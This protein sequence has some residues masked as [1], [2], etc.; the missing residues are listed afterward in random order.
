[1]N[2]PEAGP[3]NVSL[4]SAS[5]LIVDD[6][7]INIQV[8]NQILGGLYQLTFARSGQEALDL[9]LSDP[10][11]LILMDV[12][13]PE[14][15]GLATCKIIKNTPDIS[16]IPVVFIT[17]LQAAEEENACWEAGGI[18]YMIKPVNPL[19]LK[20]RIKAHLTLK[21][22]ADLLKKLAYVDGLTSVYNRRYL[23]DYVLQQ[24]AQAKRAK[25]SLSLLM[26][27]IDYFKQFNDQYGH[28]YADDQLKSVALNLRGTLRRPLDIVARYGGEEFVCVLP[29]T[30]ELG[31]NHVARLMIKSIADLKINH[32]LS[33][34]KFLTVS[35]G[36]ATIDSEQ[37][38]STDL[39]SLADKKLYKAK[40]T[41]R[42]KAV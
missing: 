20:N 10:P 32:A 28:L 38:F 17:S 23:D 4:E 6:Q 11:D 31:A 35:V 19:P 1:M 29:D 7:P 36:I 16:D 25:Q 15:D 13:M 39:I 27:D 9:C 41:G 18:D 22:Q 14:L 33:P 8:I 2:L 40:Q 24:K 26:V 30:G 5:I 3:T 42:N 12:V 37:D 34:H 21:F